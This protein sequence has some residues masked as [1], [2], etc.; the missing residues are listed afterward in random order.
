MMLSAISAVFALSGCQNLSFATGTTAVNDTKPAHT[1]APV[2]YE[3]LSHYNWTLVSAVDRNNQSLPALSA[4]KDQVI[5]QFGQQN[6]HNVT[7]YSVG[8]NNMVGQYTLSN[9]VLNIANVRQ[10]MMGCGELSGAES[11]LNSLMQGSSQ[12]TVQGTQEPVLTQITN[13]NATLVWKGVLTS[14][15]K[16]NQQGDTVFWEVSHEAQLCSPASTKVCLKVRPVEYD[17]QGIKTGE[18]N[19]SIFGGVI[20]GYT[21]ND[22]ADEVLRLKRYVVDPSDVKGKQFAYVL[23]SVVETTFIDK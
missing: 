20:D 2:S 19:W 21:H 7:R 16:Y 5:L 4:I 10:T 3:T 11:L 23:D 17:N 9:N 12:L 1:Q 8:C 14:Q 13:D 15:A 22:S 18:G 6:G